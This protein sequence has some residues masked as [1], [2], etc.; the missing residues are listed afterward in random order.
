MQKD[1]VLDITPILD[2]CI[3]FRLICMQMW[4]FP[5]KKQHKHVSLKV[6]EK[7]TALK[8]RLPLATSS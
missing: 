1:P 3:L 2:I 8:N 7:L 5:F 4:K 6:C